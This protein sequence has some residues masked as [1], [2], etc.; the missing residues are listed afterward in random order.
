MVKQILFFILCL[1]LGPRA[2][3][4]VEPRLVSLNPGLTE[5]LLALDLGSQLVGVSDYCQ[6]VSGYSLDRLG[7]ELTPK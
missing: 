5:L 1:S 6:D 4:S 3:S 7:T 2:L